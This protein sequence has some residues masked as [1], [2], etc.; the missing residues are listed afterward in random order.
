M[1][2]FIDY[3]KINLES[4]PEGGI[5]YRSLQSFVG[6]TEHLDIYQFGVMT[7]RS[8]TQILYACEKLNISV[9][10]VFGFDSCVGLPEETKEPLGQECWS[11]GAFSMLDWFEVEDTQDAIQCLIRDLQPYLENIEFHFIEGFFDDILTDD[12]VEKYDMKP[13]I[14]VDVDVDLYSSTTTL[15]DFMFRNKLI[16]PNTIIGYDDWGGTPFWQMTAD[17]ES[18][19]HR[20]KTLE[21]SINCYPLVQEG[22]EHPHVAKSFRVI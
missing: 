13:A 10:K 6:T 20:E 4:P 19:A 22:N 8:I 2:S 15:L 5:R 17:G 21:Y 7:G 1:K 16:I 9:R 14:F 12:L 11:K 18:A 3:K